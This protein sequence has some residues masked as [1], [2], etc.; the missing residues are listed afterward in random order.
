[1]CLLWCE[2]AGLVAL[3][4]EVMDLSFYVLVLSG[5]SGP[6]WVLAPGHR[7]ENQTFHGLNFR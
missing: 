1:M 7:L 5:V 4:S 2:R 6:V 3:P